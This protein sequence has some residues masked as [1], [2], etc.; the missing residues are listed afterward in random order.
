MS[1]N[2]T[3]IIDAEDKIISI[4]DNWIKFASENN[5]RN[6]DPN[7][8]IGRNLFDFIS[9]LEVKQIYRIL[10]GRVRNTGNPCVLLYR[11]DSPYLIRYMQMTIK[12]MQNK[13]VL[14]ENE[15][16]EV[17]ERQPVSIN[18]DETD[19]SENS[20]LVMCSWC[21]KIKS[22]DEWVDMEMYLNLNQFLN[23]EI[24]LRITHGVCG[25]CE[26]KYFNQA[27]TTS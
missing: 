17:Q 12:P 1:K 9:G 8:V 6:F 24:N 22:D 15:L 16:I 26:Q 13:H 7:S 5:F 21:K 2:Y 3:H 23:N 4:D 27:E 19:P 10:V 11:C 20:F 25:E 18:Y 14:F